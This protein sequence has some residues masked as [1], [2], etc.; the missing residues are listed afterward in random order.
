M[1]N[2]SINRLSVEIPRNPLKGL[3]QGKV[4]D[5]DALSIFLRIVPGLFCKYVRTSQWS[6]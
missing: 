1:R 5:D 4:Q 3:V 2:D 6:R